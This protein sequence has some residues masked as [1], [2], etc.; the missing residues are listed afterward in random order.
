MRVEMTRTPAPA[1]ASA[2]TRA[3][4]DAQARPPAVARSAKT[5]IFQIWN[6]FRGVG[7]S[8]EHAASRITAYVYGTTV[9]LAA[10][11]PLSRENAERGLS[12]LIVV[13][14][15]LTTYL[16]HVLGD[17][18]GHRARTDVPLD[19]AVLRGE[20]RDSLPILS[21][22]LVP[23]AILGLAWAGEIPGLAAQLVAEAYVVFRLARMGF[24]IERLRGERPS[25]RTFLVSFGLAGL[26]IAASFLKVA[27][28]LH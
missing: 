15:A 8:R 1:H 23:A 22:G 11:I 2:R 9:T 5:R 26:G 19:A 7:L 4:D 25:A 6:T 3:R 28:T 17:L 27:I 16:A 24:V 12:A 13:G 18:A 10:I 20:F 21:S 14:T